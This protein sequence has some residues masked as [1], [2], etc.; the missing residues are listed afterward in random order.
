MPATEIQDLVFALLDSSLALIE[1]FFAMP[2]FILLEEEYIFR[3]VLYW[4]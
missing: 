1:P 3:T 2:S 4:K